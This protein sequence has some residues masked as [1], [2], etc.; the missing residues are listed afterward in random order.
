VAELARGSV[1]DRP[2]GLTFAALGMRGLTGQL[3]LTADGKRFAVAFSRGAIV[4]AS[5]PLATDA[6]IRVALTA[7]LVSSSQVNDLTRKIAAAR[8][9]DDVEVIVE[10]LRLSP[11]HA[12]RLR[13][14]LVAQRAARTFSLE[15]GEFVVEDRVTVQ[16]VPGNELD[17]RSIVYMGTRSNL[18][19]QRIA[20]ELQSLG[21][22]FKLK[23]EAVADLPQYGFTEAEK[24]VLERLVRG[25]SLVDLVG[26][27]ELD[28]R[29]TRTVIYAL[30]SCA[31]CEIDA[32]L[33]AAAP[34]RP[35]DSD[36]PTASY[37]D[38]VS[39]EEVPTQ[40][41]APTGNIPRTIT[42]SGVPAPAVHHKTGA[43]PAPVERTGSGAIP[44][45]V[46]RTGSGAIPAPVERVG[47]APRP[48]PPSQPPPAARARAS[49]G[50][51][52]E[53]E[54]LIS[55]MVPLL[56]RGA[57]H[58]A[59][60]GVPYEASAESVRSAYFNLA[61]KLHPDRLASLGIH[62][63]Q[64]NAQRLFAQINTAFGVLSDPGKRDEYLELSRRGG[65]SAVRE[66]DAKAEALA[67]R[68]MRAE[69]AFRLGEMSLRRGQLPQ[70][71]DAFGEAVELQPNEPEYQALLAW[72]KFAAAPDKAAVA[73]ATRQALQR[74]ADAAQ[75]SPTARFYLGRIERML[76]REREAL[77]HF[78]E[79]L[80]IKP[81]HAEASAE[82]RILEQRLR[83]R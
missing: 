41:R 39:P 1:A 6:A 66:E 27:P 13:R 18:S 29:T 32:K 72:A 44:A 61:R 5:S 38:P 58:F 56:E 35:Q 45:P 21:A 81:G 43:I 77:T 48:R 74:A 63:P 42:A 36:A 4:G 60:L 19:E 47:S 15:Q 20:S 55:E 17:V 8:G 75:R 57:D 83:K 50:A 64:R 25:G 10:A 49:L 78:Q 54:K 67:A 53:T 16:V 7:N 26:D 12:Q 24:P 73:G 31:A 40:P 51:A 52:T 33:R 46:T 37:R 69:E 30:V 3:T 11:D 28:A 80:N 34:P 65:A 22:W 62:D 70:A 59:L 2:W 14:R 79:V 9:R 23:R 76:G 68:V 82:I 71:I